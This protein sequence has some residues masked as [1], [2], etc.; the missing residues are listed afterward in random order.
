MKVAQIYCLYNSTMIIYSK[1]LIKMMGS[2]TEGFLG[3]ENKTVFAE[4]K[5]KGS[6]DFLPIKNFII[7]NLQKNDL[8]ITDYFINCI[9]KINLSEEDFQY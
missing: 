6:Y 4:G 3:A 9:R 8:N 1:N 5:T 2:T 7:D